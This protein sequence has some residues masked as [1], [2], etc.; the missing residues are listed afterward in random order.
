MF[1]EGESVRFSGIWVLSCGV[2]GFKQVLG[3]VS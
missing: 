2:E 1:L 3:S